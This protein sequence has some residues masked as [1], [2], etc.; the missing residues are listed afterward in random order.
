MDRRDTS[1]SD[2]A[3]EVPDEE[4]ISAIK[5]LSSPSPLVS[6]QVWDTV[7]DARCDYSSITVRRQ[8]LGKVRTRIAV[9]VSRNGILP[10]HVPV[11][12]FPFID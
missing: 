11:R 1:F 6:Y 2:T 7:R 12:R 10:P 8:A 5:S 9:G 3:E 4:V